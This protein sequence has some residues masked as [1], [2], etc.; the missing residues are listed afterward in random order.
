MAQRAPNAARKGPIG[1]SKGII[2]FTSLSKKFRAVHHYTV[3]YGV[4]HAGRYTVALLADQP[5][6]LSTQNVT[7]DSLFDLRQL[8]WCRQ[9]LLTRPNDLGA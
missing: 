8:W 9:I 1:P 6:T 2:T 5:P 4:E 3:T 7:D